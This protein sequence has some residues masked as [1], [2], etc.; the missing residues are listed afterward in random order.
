MSD[1]VASWISKSENHVPDVLP[2]HI[3]KHH[4]KPLSSSIPVSDI[5][6]AYEELHL[7][8]TQNEMFNI[9]QSWP[10]EKVRCSM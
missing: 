3:A 5:L 1:D 6:N 4:V 9:P 2:F 7:P 8:N 10:Y